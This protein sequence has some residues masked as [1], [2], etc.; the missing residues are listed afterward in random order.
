M[1]DHSVLLP[2]DSAGLLT[3]GM[4]HVL[5]ALRAPEGKALLLSTMEVFVKVRVRLMRGEGG[6]VDRSLRDPSFNP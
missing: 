6:D 3:M 1:Y 4:Q 5:R 2:L